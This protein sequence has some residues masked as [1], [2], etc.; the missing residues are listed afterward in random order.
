MSTY[1]QLTDQV[2]MNLQGYTL[3]QDEKTFLTS[4]L[5]ATATTFTV[6]E[7]RLVSRGMVQIEDELMWVKKVDKES[8][9]VTVSPFGR[10]YMSTT[11]KT[12][13]VGVMVTDS[14]KFP[15]CRIKDT[16]NTA[17]REVYPD[18]YPLKSTSFPFV[19]ARNT[20]E[21]PADVKGVHSVT[22]EVVGPSKS[23]IGVKRFQYDPQADTGRFATGKSLDIWSSVIPGRN[24][25]VIYMT[26]PKPFVNDSDEF[27]TTTGLDP[28]VEEVIVYGTCYRLV[29]WLETARLQVQAI[30]STMRSPLVPPKAATDAGRYYFAMYQESLARAR[31]KLLQENPT[32]RHFRYI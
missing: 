3:D 21:L 4:P 5:D 26:E 15:R 17:V 18:I 8:N 22:W 23:W 12:H 29:G 25:K 32:T 2:E 1:K 10:G 30:E 27:S 31:N 6:D 13:A 11:A 16:I 14:P 7:S 9:Q 24:V 20:Y 28:Y 19:A